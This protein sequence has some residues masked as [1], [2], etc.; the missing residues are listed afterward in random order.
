MTIYYVYAYLRED[1]S[2]YYIGKGKNDRA[3]DNNDHKKH[4]IYLPVDQSRIVI[5]K[6][7]LT[8]QEALDLEA[9][10][11]RQHGRRDI[12]T[13]ILYNKTDGGVNP[14]LYG[15]HNGMTGKKH[16]EET[17]RKIRNSKLGR[18]RRNDKIITCTECNSQ[19]TAQGFRFH[20]LSEHPNSNILET[21][22]PYKCNQCDNAY[23]LKNGL[24][25]H[26]KREHTPTI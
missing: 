18:N 8:N 25:A 11:I 24:R 14:I 3:Y 2:P 15:E 21:M 26:I 20:C 23:T 19:H 7:T 9:T 12:G 22:R 1:Q 10:L 5:L 13:G 6:D 17:L 16:S 4:G